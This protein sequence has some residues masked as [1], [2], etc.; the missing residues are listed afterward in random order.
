MKKFFALFAVVALAF[1]AC[2]KTTDP[3][4]KPEPEVKPV[5]TLTSNSTI[6]FNAD[7]GNG[8]ITYTLENAKEGVKLE[9]TCEAAWVTNITTGS[10]N[11]T[12]T[13]AAN[14]T[15]EARN[16]KIFVSYSTEM[17]EVTISQA[18]KQGDEP[19]PPTPGDVVTFNASVLNGEYYGNQYGSGYNYYIMLSDIGVPDSENV[20]LNSTVYFIDIYSDVAVGSGAKVL[21]EG[22]YRFDG[23]NTYVEGTFSQEYTQYVK[24]NDEDIE[25]L[26]ACFGGTITVSAN[27][28][29]A[30]L[31]FGVEGGEILTHQVIY[32]G[33]LE[34][35]FG[36]AD[37]N[38]EGYYS[39]LTDDVNMNVTDG[40]IIGENYGDYYGFGADN[41]MLYGYESLSESGE[42]AFGHGFLLE[43][44]C[45]SS[46]TG[47]YSAFSENASSYAGSYLPGEVI[48][49]EMYYCWYVNYD[50]MSLA[51]IISG[52]VNIT[53][54][55]DGTMSIEFDV[56]DDA[57]YA[58]TGTFAGSV[59]ILDFSEEYAAATPKRASVKRVGKSAVKSVVAR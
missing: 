8:E 13:V 11:I 38:T 28:I 32:E 19:N 21:P 52:D 34:L 41:L 59:E 17:F 29:E 3:T 22:I 18:A 26:H 47:T 31:E 37:D 39:T 12:F 40:I 14:D 25:I 5:L 55:N 10:A 51:P 27:R 24:A 53:D 20:Y 6:E 1:A 35:G 43:L 48:D 2:E 56:V 16:T 7:G 54:N 58:I 30:V 57:G 44:L 46:F 4:P 36:N 23:N 15:A 42:E 45:G 50:M 9:A 49:E 33:S